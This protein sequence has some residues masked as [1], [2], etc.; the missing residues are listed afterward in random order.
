MSTDSSIL[1][2]SRNTVSV[3]NYVGT[4]V[5]Q[6]HK[7]GGGEG[8]GEKMGWRCGYFAFLFGNGK[9]AHLLSK[10]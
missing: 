9:E 10:T 4:L 2:I 5:S 3:V 8:V 7:C 6:K 1:Y